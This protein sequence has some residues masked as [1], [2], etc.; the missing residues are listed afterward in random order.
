MVQVEAWLR[1][2][3]VPAAAAARAA[4]SSPPGENRPERPVGP[5]STGRAR[6]FPKSSTERSRSPTPLRGRG[7]RSW[8]AKTASFRR[9]SLLVL[10]PAIGEIE[11]GVGQGPARQIADGGEAVARPAPVSHPS[12]SLTFQ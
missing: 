8:L 7:T 12:A 4:A 6:R 9:E 3:A 11:D 2:K 10:G 5:M 1:Q